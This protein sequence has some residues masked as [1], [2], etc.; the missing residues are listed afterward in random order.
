[1]LLNGEIPTNSYKLR[2]Y[3]KTDLYLA[4]NT[5]AYANSYKW[6]ESGMAKKTIK[7]L[8]GKVDY[9]IIDTAP[10]SVDSSVNE[11]IKMADETILVVKTD[12]VETTTVNDSILT[13]TDVGDNLAGCILNQTPPDLPFASFTG[14]G[15]DTD[16][17]RK[18]KH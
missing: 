9:I 5:H 17:R 14:A 8:K 13:I 4:L 18:R 11:I 6:I 7:S 16:T 1:L 3:K 12:T 10:I 15:D 2:R